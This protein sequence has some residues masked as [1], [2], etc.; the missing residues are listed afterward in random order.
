MRDIRERVELGAWDAGEG[1]SFIPNPSTYLN[2]HRWEDDIIPRPE[3]KPSPE[4]QAAKTQKMLNEM[5]EE[6]S[7]IQ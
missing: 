4:Q 2:Q 5:D 7:W 1:K 6:Q 3:F